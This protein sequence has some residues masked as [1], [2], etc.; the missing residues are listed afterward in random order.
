MIKIIKNNIVNKYNP[1]INRRLLICLNFDLLRINKIRETIQAIIPPTKRNALLE[2]TIKLN[3]DRLINAST[4]DRMRKNWLS[5]NLVNLLFLRGL[6]MFKKIVP[7][8]HLYGLVIFI[9]YSV[10]LLHQLVHISYL[11][12]CPRINLIA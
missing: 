10:S 12:V 11:E 6:L 1:I 7:N 4:I 9:M 5:L 3:L 2:V 8:S